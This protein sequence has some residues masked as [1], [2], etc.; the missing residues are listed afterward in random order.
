LCFIGDLSAV[1]AVVTVLPL[2]GAT[3][4]GPA[5]PDLTLPI[6][7][8]GTVSAK[9]WRRFKSGKPPPSAPVCDATDGGAFH[10]GCDSNC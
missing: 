5:V 6:A 9:E 10:I 8:L 2:A 7:F 4:R 1:L 3:L